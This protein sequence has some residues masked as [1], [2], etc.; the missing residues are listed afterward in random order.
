MGKIIRRLRPRE[1]WRI[2]EHENWFRGLAAEG[3]HLT[4]MGLTFVTF[5]EGEPKKTRYRIEVT[6]D[7]EISSEQKEVYAERG[8]DYVTRSKNF[9]VFSSPEELKAPE[10][11]PDPTE[12]APSLKILEDK[13]KFDAISSIIASIVIFALIFIGWFLRATPVLDLIEGNM[14]IQ[15]AILLSLLRMIYQS[16]KALRYTTALRKDLLE[17]KSINHQAGWKKQGR[18]INIII[19][20]IIFGI[21]FLPLIQLATYKNHNLP[22]ENANVPF[23]RLAEIEQNPNLIKDT[24]LQRNNINWASS[25]RSQWSL[26]APIKYE[27]N[28]EG[29]VPGKMWSDKSGQ[30]SPSI[31]S[32]IYQLR[33]EFLAG[34]LTSELSKRYSWKGEKQFRKVENLNLDTLLVYEGEDEI[35]ILAA[36]GKAVMYVSYY[37]FAEEGQLI[38]SV[39]GKI[40][41]ISHR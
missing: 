4:K 6:K 33:H 14:I 12:Q 11:Y 39:I 23:I 25:Y 36:K 13:F 1:Y 40:A 24:D 19:N 32:E 17:G 15:I 20:V 29:L 5:T 37:G 26:F 35:K 3:F 21:L 18:I 9:N 28:E 7:K 10:I 27:T 16:V 22:E 41:K 31:Y 8:W 30:Y 34:S 38:E 2:G